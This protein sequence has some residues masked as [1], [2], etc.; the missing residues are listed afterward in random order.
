MMDRVISLKQNKGILDLRLEETGKR[1]SKIDIIGLSKTEALDI[2]NLLGL[3]LG[4]TVRFTGIEE[5]LQ[6][7]LDHLEQGTIKNQ[8][9]TLLTSM[10]KGD[11]LFIKEQ[12]LEFKKQYPLGE[13]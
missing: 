3:E 13:K 8:L 2:Y 9:F 11:L 10:D 6:R 1:Y 4:G 7:Y 12:V 5:D